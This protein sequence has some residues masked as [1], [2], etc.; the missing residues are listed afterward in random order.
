M[1]RLPITAPAQGF[2]L[3]RFANW[4]ELESEAANWQ[5]VCDSQE[6]SLF[7]TRTWVECWRSVHKP[8]SAL[9]FAAFTGHR[10]AAMAPMYVARWPFARGPWRFVRLMGDGTNDAVDVQPAIAPGYEAQLAE[11]LLR[12]VAD[13]PEVCNGI[14][15]CSLAV[16]SPFC[17]A[18][19][20][21]ASARGW[22]IARVDR[23]HLS[24]RLPCTWEEMERKLGSK[25]RINLRRQL[26]L[27]QEHNPE[28]DRAQTLEQA[29]GYVSRM[30]VLQA[31]YKQRLPYQGRLERDQK[32]F[33][34]KLFEL[35]KCDVSILKLRGSVAAVKFG[36]LHDGRYI[37]IQAAYDPR[38]SYLGPGTL[39][40]RLFVERLILDGV[41]FY[42]FL[43]GAES[44]KT[45]WKPMREAYTNLLLAPPGFSA[46]LALWAREHAW[47][48]GDLARTLA[49]RFR[50]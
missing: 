34:T 46:K 22:S 14:E 3:V 17:R 16:Q 27:A 41:R 1:A 50:K 23:P 49:S 4:A 21:E 40:D 32:L 13:N 37:A 9:L 29:L 48:R 38:F 11:S 47:K 18:V 19:L 35:G 44:Y 5:A 12:W 43:Q 7:S 45:R 31:N 2:E 30:F 28:I 6:S 39:H 10:L 15:F 24:M 8:K 42:D 20:A 33:C 26:R 25:M 36:A